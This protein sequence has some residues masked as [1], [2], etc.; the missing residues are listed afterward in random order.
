LRNGVTVIFAVIIAAL[1]FVAMKAGTGLFPLPVKPTA[2]FELVQLK[3]VPGWLL[4]KPDAGMLVPEQ[5]VELT[6]TITLG[7]GLTVIVKL[8][9]A[10]AQPLE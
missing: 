8:D 7:N 4:L 9:A 3:V 6:G 2:V 10:P 1:V 5:T